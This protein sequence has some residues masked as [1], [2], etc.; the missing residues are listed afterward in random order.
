MNEI[1]VCGYRPDHPYNLTY[2][3]LSCMKLYKE[4]MTC[5]HYL[6]SFNTFSLQKR[7]TPSLEVESSL[8]KSVSTAA[9]TKSSSHSQDLLGLFASDANFDSP[10]EPGEKTESRLDSSAASQLSKEVSDLLSDI[11][12]LN[13]E[14]ENSVTQSSPAPALPSQPPPAGNTSFGWPDSPS[15]SIA[16]PSP[17]SLPAK[18]RPSSAQREKVASSL[19]SLPRP[20][21]RAR[22]EGRLRGTPSPTPAEVE[23]EPMPKPQMQVKPDGKDSDVEIIGEVKNPGF[24]DLFWF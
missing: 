12:N 1:K 13:S 15:F 14:K 19:I 8:K 11:N 6:S 21:S 20:P 7:P 10:G 22:P 9:V 17:P 23:D 24:S 16:D 3:I 4:R 2:T 18:T 5:Q